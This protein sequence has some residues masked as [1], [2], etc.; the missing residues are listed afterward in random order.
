RPPR[1]RCNHSRANVA[2]RRAYAS[3]RR[4]S[5]Q[6]VVGSYSFAASN[7][8]IVASLMPPSKKYSR[9]EEMMYHRAML[10]RV[11]SALGS[12]LLVSG[13]NTFAADFSSSVS[14]KEGWKLA[15]DAKEVIIYSRPHA[16]SN[17]KE[18]KAIGSIDAPSYAV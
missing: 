10:C 13:S 7:H 18:F 2:A 5:G 4:R 9:T 16:D 14:P 12:V 11:L 8:Y 3:R 1:T 17:L 6:S 15:A